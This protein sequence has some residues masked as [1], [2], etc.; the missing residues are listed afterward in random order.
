MPTGD[1]FDC[2]AHKT[3]LDAAHAANVLISYSCRSGQC[4]SCLG[5]L[6]SGQIEY[7]QG[8]PD[9]LDQHSYEAGYALFC[10]AQATSDLVIE[11]IE[12]GFRNTGN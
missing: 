4:G 7:P 5:K 11:L 10:S 8:L 6:L 12:P 3:I 2:P 9:A 1:Q